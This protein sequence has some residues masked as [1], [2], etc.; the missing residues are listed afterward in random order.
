MLDAFLISLRLRISYKVNGT[1]RVLRHV[2]L[3]KKLLPADVYS[4]GWIKVLVL[5]FSII[6]E[7]FGAF[8]GKIVYLVLM[9]ALP[10]VLLERS[11]LAVPARDGMVLHIFF[12]LTI[13]G[14]FLRNYI[15]DPNDEMYYAVFLMRMDARKYT[16]SNYFYGLIKCIFGFL[17]VIG[18]FRLAVPGLGFPSY[19]VLLLPFY[20]AGAKL[21]AAALQLIL[22]KEKDKIW[23]DCTA[24]SIMPIIIVLIA[25]AYVPL[26]FGLCIPVPVIAVLCALVTAAGIVSL[27]TVLRFTKYRA[28]LKHVGV[29]DTLGKSSAEIQTIANSA[30]KEGFLKKISSE[31]MDAQGSEKL[32]GFAYFNDIF[33]RRHRRMLTKTS[34][35]IA[36][37]SAAAVVIVCAVCIFISEAAASINAGIFKVLPVFLFVMYLINRGDTIT[38]VLFFNCDSSMMCY[39]FYRRRSVILRSFAERLKTLVRINL[40]PAMVFALGLPLV[41]LLSGGTDRPLDY[42]V[43]FFTILAMSVF[44]SVHY[45]TLYYLL[46]PY[47]EGLVQKGVGYRVA[48]SLTYLVCYMGI[49]VKIN[50]VWFGVAVC[51]FALVYIPVALFLVYR[52]APR[53]FRL[54]R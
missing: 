22:F 54:R 31:E 6:R 36:L 9:I 29:K 20:T 42:A 33:V 4:A 50:S 28:L 18:V 7:I 21:T 25:A 49:Q 37:G 24:W 35:R 39:N 1:L 27:F 3:L 53:T 47:T 48:A 17:L 11:G 52:L 23:Q 2:P 12:V 16:V 30:A 51:L 15:F 8:L 40:L 26:L 41:L 45:L 34:R 46:Q 19:F 14:T 44:F 10:C 38:R 13:I 32:S 43:L 5:I